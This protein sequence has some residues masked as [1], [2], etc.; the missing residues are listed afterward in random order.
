MGV[1]MEGVV[2]GAGGGAKVY[3]RIVA[4]KQA[5]ECK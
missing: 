3:G 4:V 1:G 5:R 2:L